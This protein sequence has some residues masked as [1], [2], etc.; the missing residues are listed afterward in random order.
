M[1]LPPEMGMAPVMDLPPGMTIPTNEEF[2]ER[3]QIAS[4]GAFEQ[5]YKNAKKL[6]DAL[7]KGDQ[8]KID[9]MDFSTEPMVCRCSL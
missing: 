7:Q 5:V 8:A 2:I 1:S 9:R 6:D 4:P 3:L